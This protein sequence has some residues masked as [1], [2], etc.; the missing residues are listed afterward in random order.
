MNIIVFD[1]ETIGKVS[2]DLLNIGYRIVDINPTTSDYKTLITRDYLVKDLINNA[3]YC[4]NDD[5]VGAEKYACYMELLAEKRIIK[6]SLAKI[7]DI[8]KRDIKRY[9]VLFGYA[10]NCNFDLDKFEKNAEKYGLTNPLENLSVYDIWDYA[11]SYICNTALYKEWCLA[12]GQITESQR[13]I[14]SSVEAV[15]RYLYRD[16]EFVEQHTALDDTQHELHILAECV[17]LGCDITKAG[18]GHKLVPSDLIITEK[19]NVNGEA[20]EISYKRKY[21]RNGVTYYKMQGTPQD[22]LTLSGMALG[23]LVGCLIA[24]YFHQQQQMES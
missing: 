15:S 9:N 13:Y 24:H 8:M 6:H 2:Q 21:S 22:M 4:L 17:K 11:C 23:L 18:T 19:L 12:T 3:V 10:Y 1:T 14:G 20:I 16:L 5:F 7:F